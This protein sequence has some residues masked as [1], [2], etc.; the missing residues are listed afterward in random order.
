[1]TL[2]PI[3]TIP[4]IGE[5]IADRYVINSLLGVGGMT[6]VYLAQD[7]QESCIVAL[8]FINDTFQAHPKAK[9]ALEHEGAILRQ[10]N[11]PSIIK[12][13]RQGEHRDHPFLVLEYNSGISLKRAFKQPHIYLEGSTLRANIVRQLKAMVFYLHQ[14]D[15]V[16]GDLKPENILLNNDIIQ[17]LDFGLARYYRN[18]SKTFDPTELQSYTPAYASDS[19]KAGQA[20]MPKDDLYALNKILEMWRKCKNELN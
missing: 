6:L 8:K 18:S 1:M 11:H 14:Q 16:H 20:A 10:L 2:P 7:L 5:F 15:I 13:L 4:Q 19:V 9:E 12:C 17:L 3:A